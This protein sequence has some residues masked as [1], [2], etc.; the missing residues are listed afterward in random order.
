MQRAERQQLEGVEDD[1][2]SLFVFQSPIC[3]RLPPVEE[4][5]VHLVALNAEAEGPVPLVP[6]L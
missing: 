1:L 4:D 3:Q 2:W 6:L 5:P